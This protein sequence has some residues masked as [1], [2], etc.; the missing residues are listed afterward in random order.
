MAASG[1]LRVGERP[2]T[3]YERTGVALSE[4]TAKDLIDH[5]RGDR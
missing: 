3:R 1:E 4:G 2:R 5:V